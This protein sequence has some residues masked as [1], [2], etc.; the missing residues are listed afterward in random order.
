MN[1][2]RIQF[3]TDAVIA[4]IITIMVL[5][6]HVPDWNTRESLFHLLP[7][8]MSY[9]MSFV[10]I[11]IYR[12][13]HH[14]LTFAVEKVDGRVLWSNNLL[15]FFI[16]LVPF[17]TSWMAKNSFSATPVMLYGIILL[18]CALSYSL[19]VRSL[20]RLHDWKSILSKAIGNDYKGKISLIAYTLAIL[21]SFVSPLISIILYILVSLMWLIP[22]KRI[23]N[24][25]PDL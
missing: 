7:M 22:D 1:K 4:I 5:E 2:D 11:A 19:L 13:N 21:L 3:F 6:F 15:L 9:I 17:S 8:F 16:S 10:F 12:N 18:A 25:V 23:E 14:H 20:L 24:E